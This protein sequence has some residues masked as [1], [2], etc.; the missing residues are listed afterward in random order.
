MFTRVGEAQRNPFTLSRS[1]PPAAISRCRADQRSVIGRAGFH[2]AQG[3]LLIAPYADSLHP[4]RA[5]VVKHQTEQVLNFQL[6][7]D[8]FVRR[9][10]S[11]TARFT[12]PY[13]APSIGF[14]SKSPFLPI[15][16]TN[17][18]QIDNSILI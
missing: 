4:E 2:S 7:F 8:D 5:R 13:N 14:A 9:I 3:A 18:I 1:L 15:A 11:P 17:I 12:S 10:V 16:L 6:G